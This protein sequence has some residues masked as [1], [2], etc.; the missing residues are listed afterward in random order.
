MAKQKLTVSVDPEVLKRAKVKK[1]LT[2]RTLSHV[3]ETALR[4][5]AEDCPPIAKAKEGTT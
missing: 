3:I 2:G 5:W 4:K 1:A